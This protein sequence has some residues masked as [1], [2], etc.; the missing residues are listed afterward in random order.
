MMQVN[1]TA[2]ALLAQGLV[3]GMRARRWG[4]IVNVSSVFSQVTKEKRAAYSSSK[5]GLNGLT[6]TLAVELGPDNILVNS[7]APG[8][9]DTELTK[10]NNPPQDLAAIARTIPLR[11]LAQTDEI[12]RCAAFLCSEDNTYLTGQTIVVDGGFTCQ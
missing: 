7:I 4:R 12:A 9:V 8:Y 1:L 5:A 3:G 6:R 11:R 10:R 2:P